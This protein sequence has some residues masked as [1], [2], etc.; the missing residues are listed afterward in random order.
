MDV[1]ISGKGTVNSGEYEEISVSG[2][3][4]L[5]GLVRCKSLHCSGS[6]K[7][8]AE[9]E[10]AEGVHVSGSA[11]FDRALRAGNVKVSGSLR[12]DGAVNVDD[13]TKVSGSMHCGSIKSNLIKVSGKLTTEGD[14]EAEEIKISGGI[15]C[16]GLLNA[17]RMEIK[18]GGTQSFAESIGGSRILIYPEQLGKESFS[19]LPLLGKMIGVR[20]NG[21]TVQESI[22]GDEIALEQVTA[23]SVV[24]R[25]VAIGKGC[26]IETVQYSE[27]VEIDEDAKVEHCE[28]I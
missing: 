23:K 24:G 1:H 9:V 12:V 20:S 6:V 4:I 10:C 11:H 27:T 25:V 18:L 19:R 16:K 26:C 14:A 21:M 17:E 5:E 7:G 13:V 28:K 15:Q 3:G 22:E 2:S 8:N